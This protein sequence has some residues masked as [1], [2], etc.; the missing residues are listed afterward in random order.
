VA[1]LVTAATVLVIGV[2]LSRRRARDEAALR[3]RLSEEWNGESR[4]TLH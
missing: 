4:K 1:S 2:Q 3:R